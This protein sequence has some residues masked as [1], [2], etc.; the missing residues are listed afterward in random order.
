[1]FMGNNQFFWGVVED[2]MDPLYLGRL[3]VRIFGIHSHLKV[4]TD[5]E[6]SPTESLLWCHMLQPTTS[7]AISGVGTSPTGIVEGSHVMGI[8]RDNMC[9]DGIVIGTIGGIPVVQVNPNDGFNDPNGNYPRYINEP[10]TNTRARGG[11]IPPVPTP[12]QGIQP[13]PPKETPYTVE[14]QDLNKDTAT[15]ADKTPADDI[16]PNP[17]PGLTLEEMLRRDEGV[18]IKVY[19]DSLGYP[20]IGIG[21]LILNK[22]TKNTTEIYAALS[23]QLGRNVT[24]GRITNEEATKLFEIDLSQTISDTQRHLI[25]G[26]VYASL[27]DTRKMAIINM[28]FQMGV[29]GVADFTE[30]LA[31][32]MSKDWK[33]AHDAMLDSLWANQTPGRA[34]RVAKIILNGNLASY[35]VTGAAYSIRSDGGILFE[36]PNS[37]YAAEYPYNHV[38]ESESGHIQEF[39]DTAGAERYFRKHP[40]GTFEE[41]HPD[42]TRVI[43][44]VG[45][46]YEIV[47]SNRNVHIS[48]NLQVVIDGN[49]TIYI[50]G[51]CDQTVDGSVTQLVRGDVTAQIDGSITQT[52]NGDVTNLVKG[53][54]TQTVNGDVTEQVDGNTTNTTVGDFTQTVE[55][56]YILNVKGS[57]TDKV[58]G[59][60]NREATN[61]TD[62]ATG[63]HKSEGGGA[64]TTLNASVTISGSTINLN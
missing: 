27:D 23:K 32:I 56:N 19:W 51:N 21:H 14:E 24:D 49:S 55:G 54:V 13:T 3:K 5:T 40:I 22:K 33:N 48:G 64:T 8:F 59:N 1:M 4:S 47:K 18:R 35:G 2:R 50:Q 15:A 16:K 52:V 42:G 12:G 58:D 53:D 29:D 57:K 26:P 39:D 6:G 44:I 61:V 7:A 28:C 37:P 17:I 10:D 34:N 25:V 46:D 11:R 20:T 30:S 43:K 60:W 63:T 62:K 36:E 9:Q 45:E 31:Y 38:Y 41:I